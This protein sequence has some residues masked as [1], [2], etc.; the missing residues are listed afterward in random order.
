[1]F[2]TPKASIDIILGLIA[3]TSGVRTLSTYIN[4]MRD[5]GQD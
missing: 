2:Q 3:L 1:M 5:R 4:D